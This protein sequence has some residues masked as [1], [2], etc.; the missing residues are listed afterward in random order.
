MENGYALLD[1]S[2]PSPECTFCEK[3]PYPGEIFLTNKKG[4][5]LPLP[6]NSKSLKIAFENHNL[7]VRWVF[8][9]F[10]S[11][12]LKFWWFLDGISADWTMKENSRSVSFERLPPG[13]YTLKVKVTD[14][15]GHE[16][17]IHTLPV[18]VLPPWYSSLVAKTI[19]FLIIGILLL[20][21]IQAIIRKIKKDEERKREEN[22]RELVKLKNEKLQAEIAYK[23]K[24]LGSSTMMIIQKNKILSD[25]KELLQKQKAFQNN[26]LSGKNFSDIMRK[27]E[28]TLSSHDD[29]KTFDIT[30]DEAHESFMK[31]LKSRYPDLS[32]KDIRLCAFL[33]MNLPSKE[34]APLL[35]I[36]VRGVENHR[37][38]LRR[39]MNLEH[40]ENLIEVIL[41][42]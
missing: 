27:I 5:I 11:H 22:E 21:F 1:G 7:T 40:D 28:S 2:F 29:W 32:P 38:R 12:T 41:S 6:A 25:L 4:K 16:S 8:P 33:R 14:I 3:M 37:Y 13:K 24:E 10:S 35:G 23:V 39:K 20:I 26:S 30:F 19:S 15:W 18:V 31:N 17:R 9:H 34:I 42:L 36:S